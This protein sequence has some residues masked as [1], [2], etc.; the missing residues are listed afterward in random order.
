MNLTRA[1]G[2]LP[3]TG[4]SGESMA[5]RDNPKNAKEVVR[6]LIAA[7]A[8]GDTKIMLGL[9][10][11]DAVVI[12]PGD[13]KV[14]FNGRWEGKGSIR[15]CFQLIGEYL[16]IR[17]HTIRLLFGEG[18]HVC[19]IINETSASKTTGRLIKQDTA[20]HFRVRSGKI[21]LWQ[22]FEDTAQVAWAWDDRAAR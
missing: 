6:A 1:S 18:E 2:R 5:K 17:D 16:E 7:L 3:M 4:S 20:W 12:T 21:V 11:D 22:V 15:Q 13:V 9:L 8:K 10:D 14:P 19:V